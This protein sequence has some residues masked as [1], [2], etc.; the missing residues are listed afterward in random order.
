M[1]EVKLYDLGYC[2]DS[3]LT[4]V[5]SVSKYKDDYVFCYNKKRQD[6]EIPGGHIEETEFLSK[7]INIKQG[8]L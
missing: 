6:W 3:E 1:L 2:K 5:A 8:K 4:R 7:K